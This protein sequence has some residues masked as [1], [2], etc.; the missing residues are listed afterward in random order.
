M[1]FQY[2]LCFYPQTYKFRWNTVVSQ[3]S[4]ADS[5]VKV[6]SFP[7]PNVIKDK[8]RNTEDRIKNIVGQWSKIKLDMITHKQQKQQQQKYKKKE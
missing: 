1:W 3:Y 7:S 2:F 4:T 5:E 6:W 8:T